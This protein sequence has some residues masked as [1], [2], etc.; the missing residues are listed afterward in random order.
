MRIDA[1]KEGGKA[2][3][4]KHAGYAQRLRQLSGEEM[5]RAYLADAKQQADIKVNLPEKAPVN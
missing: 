5:F 1:V 2:D 4:A 3:D